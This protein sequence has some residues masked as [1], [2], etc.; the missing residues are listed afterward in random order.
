MAAKSSTGGGRTAPAE[1]RPPAAPD[2][3]EDLLARAR[4]L[5]A[6]KRARGEIPENTTEALD[7][8]FTEVAPPGARAEAD[9]LEAL[10]E[11]LAH[12]S[13]DTNIPIDSNRRGAGWAVRLVKRALRP[14]VAW[15]IRHISDQ[16]N[17]YS[18]AHS[19]VLRALVQGIK[20]RESS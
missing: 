6:E 1:K 4:T 17:A 11:V 3:Y 13:F 14:L 7:R 20:E 9:S 18:A 15:Q 5:A 12:Y 10:V 8:L 16:L 19:E 2:P